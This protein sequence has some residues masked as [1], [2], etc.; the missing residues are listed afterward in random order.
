MVTLTG[1]G[2]RIGAGMFDV[3]GGSLI[4]GLMCAMMTSLILGMGVSTT[5][6]YIITSTVAAPILI[7]MG[8]PLLASHLFCFYFGI[9]A[10]IT[11]P[12]AL[13]AY[14]G[15][16][17]AKSNPFKTGVNAAKIAIGAFIIP[18]M[19]AISPKMILIGGTFMEALPMIITAIIGMIG[20][21]GSFIGHLFGPI[22][23]WWRLILFASG[24]MLVIPGLATDI[25]GS[26]QIAFVII[27]HRFFLNKEKVIS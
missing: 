23:G 27:L 6:N 25:A 21:S 14:A 8:I 16:A 13:A 9:I 20:I 4:L 24:F 7:K 15:S 22:K 1:L 10:D 11:P 18:Y 17:I 5:S 19:F 26:L 2:Q 3:V 12:V